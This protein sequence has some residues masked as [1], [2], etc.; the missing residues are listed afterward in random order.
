[1]KGV[2]ITAGR[3]ALLAVFGLAAACGTEKTTPTKT[4]QTITSAAKDPAGTIKEVIVATVQNGGGGK[5]SK[6]AVTFKAS[7]ASCDDAV[8]VAVVPTDIG[9]EISGGAVFSTG[10]DGLALTGVYPW[11]V[12]SMGPFDYLI[13]WLFNWWRFG[14]YAP[15]K[16][17]VP[18][19]GNAKEIRLPVFP[20]RGADFKGRVDVESFVI[21]ECG[22]LHPKNPKRLCLVLANTDANAQDEKAII[23]YGLSLD[24][25][26]PFKEADIE[27][28]AVR[29]VASPQVLHDG[30]GRVYQPTHE[31][32]YQAMTI[33]P[34]DDVFTNRNNCGTA[35]ARGVVCNQTPHAE[36]GG[37]LLLVSRASANATKL[38]PTFIMAASSED[39][40]N[41]DKDGTVITL[42]PW[43]ELP[44]LALSAASA[45]TAGTTDEFLAVLPDGEQ[46]NLA[47]RILTANLPDLKAEDL[48]AAYDTEIGRSVTSVYEDLLD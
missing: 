24:P 14:W 4:I 12:W 27:L 45:R 20:K 39:W 10:G 32:S 16:N 43:G 19:F 30:Y 33:Y 35:P 25:A 15:L 40:R 29:P 9:A 42:E 5:D 8:D 21:V 41:P 3:F 11:F 36:L 47:A 37:A 17:G 44:M 46:R 28:L 31:L 22:A 23:I 18:D 6:T 38:E 48:Q 26:E 7:H 1:M 34:E 2:P 13:D